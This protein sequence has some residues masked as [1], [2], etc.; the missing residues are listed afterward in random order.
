MALL[1]EGQKIF[2]SCLTWEINKLRLLLNCYRTLQYKELF[3]FFKVSWTLQ[4]GDGITVCTVIEQ[5]RYQTIQTANKLYNTG[6]VLYY[7][8]YV[9]NNQFI[10][11]RNIEVNEVHLGINEAIHQII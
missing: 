4:I 8:R 1:D 7:V 11:F 9:Y 3:S 6:V 10:D 5:T 2:L